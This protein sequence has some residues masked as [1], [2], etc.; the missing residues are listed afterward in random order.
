MSATFTDN[1]QAPDRAATRTVPKVRLAGL[2]LAV[3]QA[4]GL[5]GKDFLQALAVTGSM[6]AAFLLFVLLGQF[7]PEGQLVQISILRVVLRPE[8][9][10]M[11]GWFLAMGVLSAL[12]VS[13]TETEDGTWHQLRTLPLRPYEIFVSKYLAS[14]AATVVGIG[15]ISLV[16]GLMALT[17]LG[18]LPRIGESLADALRTMQ[19]F[20]FDGFLQGTEK[21]YKLPGPIAW[22]MLAAIGV[23]LA[24]GFRSAGLVASAI[25]L[26]IIGA[27]LAILTEWGLLRMGRSNVSSG[28][29]LTIYT[30]LMAL[31]APLWPGCVD[32]GLR[33]ETRGESQSAQSEPGILTPVI[34]LWNRL[35]EGRP[36][37]DTQH[38]MVVSSTAEIITDPGSSA[39]LRQSLFLASLLFAAMVLF[40]IQVASQTDF[41]LPH[42]LLSCTL[43][44]LAGAIGA[45]F[46]NRGELEP[47]RHMAGFLPVSRGQWLRRRLL[48]TLPMVALVHAGT[49]AGIFLANYS[50]AHN[51]RPMSN[52]QFWTTVGTFSPFI[53]GFVFQAALLRLFMGGISAAVGLTVLG[54]AAIAPIATVTR[55]VD[56]LATVQYLNL[57][58]HTVTL[59][60]NFTAEILALQVVWLYL[61]LVALPVALLFL[62]WSRTS[63][64]LESFPRRRAIGAAVFLLHLYAQFLLLRLPGHHVWSVVRG[65]IGL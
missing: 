13:A 59:G 6:A 41:S 51:T 48:C 27:L 20:V 42:W 49:I 55:Q 46:W 25:T 29:R 56:P 64:P 39:Y 44:V 45:A 7:V 15:I 17:G 4:F 8:M 57:Y 37:A 22:L 43:V 36:A 11:V 58:P 32:K 24:V 10:S 23:T 61:V 47:G 53:L 9:G 40:G 31:T 63:I 16:L 5:G 18:T 34:A 21:L 26:A 28:G 2:R 12:V 35:T 65:W 1:T 52:W 54:M 50:N 62:S 38:R 3:I 14:V 60:P 19:P 30:T 33:S